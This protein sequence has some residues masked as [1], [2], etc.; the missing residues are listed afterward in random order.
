MI[1]LEFHGYLLCKQ[2][3]TTWL[4]TF[5]F[6]SRYLLW[7]FI[8]YNRKW[9]YCPKSELALQTH[10]DTMYNYIHYSCAS[11]LAITVFQINNTCIR[12]THVES[13]I[14]I[15]RKRERQITPIILKRY[16][17]YFDC[18]ITLLEYIP[19]IFTYFFFAGTKAPL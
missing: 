5:F 1:S 15:V 11:V 9:I 7:S 19:W 13:N 4:S 18:P 3:S 6:A 2:I 8:E 16:L 10:T 17:V 12:G 14:C